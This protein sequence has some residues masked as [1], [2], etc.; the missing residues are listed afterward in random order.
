MDEWNKNIQQLIDQIDLCI[1]HNQG[2]EPTLGDLA[3]RL[4]Y[5]EYHLSRKFKEITGMQL[6]DYLRYRRLAFA[7]KELR[8]SSRNS[9]ESVFHTFLIKLPQ[10]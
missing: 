1:Q 2:K 4:G 6:R 9:N 7:L 8:D 3:Q 10:K 5:S